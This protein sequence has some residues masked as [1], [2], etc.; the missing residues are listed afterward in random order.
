LLLAELNKL[1]LSNEHEEYVINRYSDRKR[2]NMVHPFTKIAEQTGIGRIAR[3][4][5]HMRASRAT[6]DHREYG[7]I[8]E[9]VWLDHSK[10]VTHECYLMVTDEDYASTTG[11]QRK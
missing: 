6:E 8:T 4:F 11:T 10:K 7:A 2:I 5:D 3:P 9:S 1:R